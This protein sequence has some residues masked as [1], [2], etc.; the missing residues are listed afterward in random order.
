MLNHKRV[1]LGIIIRAQ[2]IAEELNERV[3]DEKTAD[4]CMHSSKCFA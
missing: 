4:N 2:D 1:E 3:R